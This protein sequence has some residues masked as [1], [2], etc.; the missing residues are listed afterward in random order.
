MGKKSREKKEKQSEEVKKASEVA[1]KQIDKLAEARKV[2]EE[3]ENARV[4]KCHTEI[5]E[6][7][8][9]HNCQLGVNMDVIINGQRPT[10][11]MQAL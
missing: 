11:I 7:L 4:K 6:I 3:E 9:K 2:L 8:K 5:T 10:V 1:G